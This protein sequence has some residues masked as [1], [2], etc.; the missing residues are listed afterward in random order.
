MVHHE[1]ACIGMRVMA[2]SSVIDG[3]EVGDGA[4]GTICDLSDGAIGVE[5]D[6]EYEQ[7][8]DCHRH[9]APLHGWYVLQAD[10]VEIHDEVA[11]MWDMPFQ[12][13]W[14]DGSENLIVYT[15]TE[16]IAAAFFE[17][18]AAFGYRWCDGDEIDPEMLYYQFGGD[19]AYC[20]SVGR[21]TISVCGINEGDVY[22]EG[23]AGPN[24]IKCTF[25][26][27]CELQELGVPADAMNGLWEV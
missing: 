15:P 26:N 20:V 8:H 24:A 9:C 2:C 6:N 18:L 16:D 25:G 5:W 22:L 14:L 11:P 7:C 19:T 1:D 27:V 3:L 13:E 4:K 12:A 10:I 23:I 17:T 21:R